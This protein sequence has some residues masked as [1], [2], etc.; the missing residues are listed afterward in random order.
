MTRFVAWEGDDP[1]NQA[2]WELESPRYTGTF[3]SINQ[4]GGR[5]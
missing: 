1:V 3:Q 5:R 2:T 4:N